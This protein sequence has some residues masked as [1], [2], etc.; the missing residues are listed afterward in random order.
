MDSE[1]LMQF[2]KY[3]ETINFNKGGQDKISLETRLLSCFAVKMPSA[4]YTK[5]P[6]RV[7]QKNTFKKIK[8]GTH[9]A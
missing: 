5:L 2:M 8:S 9:P 6:T 4:N 7:F 3:T 1:L